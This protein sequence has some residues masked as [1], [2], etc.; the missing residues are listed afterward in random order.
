MGTSKQDRQGARTV[1]DVERKYSF[2][3][4]FAEVYNIATDAKKTAEKAEKTAD[5]AKNNPTINHDAVFNALTEDGKC[6]GLYRDP[7]TGDIYIN[8]A[9]IKTGK[10]VMTKEIFIEPG[11]EI[12]TI[13][14]NHLVGNVT[15]PA[16]QI[17][18]Y[19][20]DNNGQI[21]MYDALLAKQAADG[22]I[23]LASWSGAKMSKVEC[24]IDFFDEEH[25]I[26]FKGTD[27]WGKSF[28]R[29]I[30]IKSA[31]LD[32]ESNGC[33]YRMDGNEKEWLNPNKVL[34]QEYRTAERYN[35]NIVYTKLMELEFDSEGTKAVTT[36]IDFN[37]HTIIGI[38]YTFEDGYSVWATHPDVSVYCQPSTTYYDL[39][40]T[41]PAYGI[42]RVEIKYI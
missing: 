8:A 27:M 35:G 6:Q 9:Y 2:G 24:V 7:D 41:A 31:F 11:A 42:C 25:T 28:D 40:V 23:S 38:N 39:H 30:G 34:N 14:M 36:M 1:Q 10:L 20:F 13:I 29:S 32:A 3:E 26:R 19:D 12:A 17:P 5:E 4:S 37:K 16:E 22:I 15:I 33:I 18:L 21:T